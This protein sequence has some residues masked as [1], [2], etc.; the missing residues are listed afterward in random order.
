MI[1]VLMALATTFMI[2]ALPIKFFPAATEGDLSMRRGDLAAIR[3]RDNVL[4]ACISKAAAA[5]YPGG[6]K[7]KM[8]VA[9]VHRTPGW[10]SRN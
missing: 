2:S 4:L 8:F 10:R 1:I 9:I 6:N 5:S 3:T 7:P